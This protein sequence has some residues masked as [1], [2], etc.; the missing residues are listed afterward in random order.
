MFLCLIGSEKPGRGR[1]HSCCGDA[2]RFIEKNK[3]LQRW[4][5]RRERKV[6]IRQWWPWEW[7]RGPGILLK[8][9]E[10]G[11]MF[12]AGE[13]GESGEREGFSRYYP[14]HH[15]IITALSSALLLM[16]DCIFQLALLLLNRSL[17]II[18]VL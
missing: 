14:L 7:K 2:R 8:E 5:S 3:P 18:D 12:G 15:P 6:Y 9:I 1:S 11:L 4:S 10:L 16:A 17:K 13:R